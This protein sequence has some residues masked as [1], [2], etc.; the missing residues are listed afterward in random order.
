MTNRN[1][2]GQL[3]FK[4]HIAAHHRCT[5]LEIDIEQLCNIKKGVSLDMLKK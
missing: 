4:L 5:E 3:K 1:I 2:N